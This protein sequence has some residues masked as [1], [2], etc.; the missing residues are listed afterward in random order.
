MKK[1]LFVILFLLLIPVLSYAEQKEYKFAV[2]DIVGLEELQREF[3]AFQKTLSESTG[4]NIK[5]YPV[6]SRTVVV[7]AFR[8]GRLDFALTGP[9]EY[10]ILSTK[11]EAQPIVGLTRPGYYSILV[12]KA[13][14]AINSIP[15][16][17]GKKVAFGDYG[18]TSYHLAPLQMI[19]DGG[20]N[21]QED[22]KPVNLSKLVAWKSFVRGKVD[23]IG[24]NQSRF[25]LFKSKER[26]P[27]DAYK[28][29]AKG[30]ELPN[31]LIVAAEHVPAEVNA[32]IQQA[33]ADNGEKL[34]LAI[35]QGERNEKYKEMSFFTDI[36]DSD[37]NYVREMYRTAGYAEF[38][39]TK[40]SKEQ[41]N[42]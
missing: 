31:D 26:L 29:I 17:K 39:G 32:K 16:L 13:E 10:V 12:A 37:Y 25:E 7:E 27:S 42:G 20:L 15:D 33:F 28:I 35:L 19:A 40:N 11:T 8:S 9:A 21:P 36:K 5:L 1:H 6:T 23:A 14:S 30:P 41:S 3:E 34:L 38:A 4:L 24:I 2:T 22:I 18:S